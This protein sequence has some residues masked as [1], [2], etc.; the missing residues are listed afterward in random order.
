MAIK[1]FRILSLILFLSA[2]SVA[3]YPTIISVAKGSTQS[4]DLDSSGGS[5]K[6]DQWTAPDQAKAIAW[7]RQTVPFVKDILDESWLSRQ[8]RLRDQGIDIND[9]YR[10]Y[11]LLNSPIIKKQEDNN[12]PVRFMHA[13]HAATVKDCSLCHHYSPKDPAAKETTRCS[14]CHQEPNHPK[15]PD[16]IGLKAAYHQQC[17]N[18]HKD[19]KQGPVEC[20]GCHQSNVPDHQYMV[21]LPPNPEPAEVTSGCLMCHEDAGKDMLSSS[22][23][24]WRGPSP[25]TKH[26]READEH[27]K[28]TTAINNF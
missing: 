8:Q 2:I 18:C 5:S 1:L 25:Y 24:L 13:R 21:N 6:A 3:P 28:A 4:V 10:T 14:A 9:I 19:M 12:G 22:H 23:W 17:I 7:A 16:R 20:N 15:A 27:G 11:F 26:H